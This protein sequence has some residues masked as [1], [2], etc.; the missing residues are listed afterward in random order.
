MTPG[1]KGGCVIGGIIGLLI[2]P[3][4]MLADYLSAYGW[5]PVWV[6]WLWPSSYML[7]ATAGESDF[8]GLVIIAV[9]ILA[10]AVLY[11]VLGGAFAGVLS[12]H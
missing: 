6:K 9:S 10:N 4:V 11:S 12:K 8:D 3:S 2:P 5:W 1:T 7:I